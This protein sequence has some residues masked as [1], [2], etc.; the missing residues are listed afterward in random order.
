M[1]RLLPLAF[2]AVFLCLAVGLVS[3]SAQ[4]LTVGVRKGDSFTYYM[5]AEYTSSVPNATVAVP[6]FEANNTDWVR[7]DITGSSGTVITSVYTLHYKNGTEQ[8][9]NGQ[10]DI[11]QNSWNNNNS[12]FRGVPICPANLQAGDEALTLQLTINQTI[13]SKC[14]GQER[15]LNHITWN[16]TLER[17]ELYFDKATGM[18]VDMYRA[19]AFVNSETGEVVTKADIIKLESTNAWS[20]GNFPPDLIFLIVFASAI[21]LTALI[22][23]RNRLAKKKK[24]SKTKNLL[25]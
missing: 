16:S 7:I 8:R 3:V 12:E 24:E 21:M 5:G 14:L 10:T 22:L 15:Q 17:G 20:K 6:E 25:G 13:T 9:I 23:A 4:A 1:R 11:A 18:L 2:I 19:H